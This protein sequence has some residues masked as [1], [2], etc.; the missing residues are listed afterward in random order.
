MTTATKPKIRQA[1][2]DANLALIASTAKLLT[3]ADRVR[4]HRDRLMRL[5]GQMDEQADEPLQEASR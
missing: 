3:E 2:Q 4:Q 1:I 5:I